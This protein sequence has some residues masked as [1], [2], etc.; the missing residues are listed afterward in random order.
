MHIRWTV[1]LLLGCSLCANAQG[2]QITKGNF[3]FLDE[4]NTLHI[5]FDYEDV[6]ISK[7]P[8]EEAYLDEKQHDLNQNK[9]GS[10]DS[11]REHWITDR[12]R[13]FN[14]AFRD[15]FFK[16]IRKV[17][18][19]NNEHSASHLMIVHISYM[20]PG[21]KIHYAQKSAEINVNAQFYKT[22]NPT[23]TLASVQFNR[24]RG[25]ET[26]KEDKDTRERLIDAFSTCGKELGIFI[27]QHGY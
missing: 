5:V 8:T 13:Y 21:F 2:I 23:D 20:E 6:A 11:W 25:K 1:F 3:D 26:G 17:N 7:Y 27:R 4:V 14:P 9:A 16:H 15:N 19:A 22:S 18:K 12:T 24:C 10:G